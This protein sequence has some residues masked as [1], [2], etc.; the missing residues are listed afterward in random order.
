MTGAVLLAAAVFAF[1]AM[2]QEGRRLSEIKAKGVVAEVVI[3]DKAANSESYTDRKGR[4]KTRTIYRMTLSHDVNAELSY[5]DWKAGRTFPK[6]IYPAVTT[7]QIETGQSWHEAFA[8]GDRTTVI[9]EPTDY[10]SMMLT[11]ELEYETSGWFVWLSRAAAAV[12]GLAGLA[13]I[14]MGWRK[15]QLS[16]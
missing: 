15:R 2:Q 1:F 4:T 5:A 11:D 3:A 14:G 6:P 13:L 8:K 16:A 10:K 9:R 12:G 7:T